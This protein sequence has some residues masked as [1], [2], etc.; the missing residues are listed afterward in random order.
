[1]AIRVSKGLDKGSWQRLV[2]RSEKVRRGIADSLRGK[3]ARP[4][5]LG[6]FQK[7]NVCGGRAGMAR[8]LADMVA[9]IVTA[10]RHGVQM[11]AMPEMALQGYFTPVSGSVEQA[12][13]ANRELA[14]TVGASDEL[15]RLQTA[16]RAARMV[17]AFGFGERA[18][19]TIY[20]SIGLIDA[21]GSWLGVRRKNP[22]YPWGYETKV[23][24]EPHPSRRCC[25]FRTRYGTVGLN[26]CFDGEFPETV[27]QMALAGAQV[28]LWCNAPCGDSKLGTSHRLNQSGAHAQ[29]NGL[30]VACAS[31]AA[32]NA[33][34]T[35]NIY[36]PVGEP[37]VVLSVDR[38]E[39]GVA[40]AN[41]ALHTDWTIWR[42]R[43]YQWPRQDGTRI[44]GR[45]GRT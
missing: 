10:R 41:L 25:V 17:V 5:V 43:L 2:A 9:A 39:L 44:R 24:A 20:N 26:D 45:G 21:D 33:T 38:E 15:R 34:G 40:T 8:N 3:G 19:R 11:L 23:F 27:R 14:V 13:A 29:T 37:L 12:I 16:A 4:V 30:Y 22:L 35:S 1:M 31:C 18:G 32:P 7:R 28:L 36:S 42:E 6:V